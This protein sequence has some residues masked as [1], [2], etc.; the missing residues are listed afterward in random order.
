MIVPHFQR[1]LVW[2][3]SS[4]S[5]LLESLYY[6]T[7]CGSIIL[8]TPVNAS[9]QGTPLGKKPQYLIVDGQQRIRSLRN[10]FKED[11]DESINY[12]GEEDDSAVGIENGNSEEDHEGNG[13]WCL[14]LGRVR[15]LEED[16]NGGKRFRL[17]R[18]AN[19][20]R[21][22]VKD[23]RG[24]P[25]IDREALLPL[26]WFLEHTDEQ[27]ETSVEKKGD[28][29]LKK[30]AIAVLG[31][32]VVKKKLRSILTSPLFHVSTRDAADTLEDVVGIY[33][34]INTA[35]KR[36]ESEEKAFANLVSVYPQVND[37]LEEFFDASDDNQE[38]TAVERRD[39]LL[40]RQKEN[41]FGFKLFMRTFVQVLAYHSSRTIGAST[42]SFDSVN[43]DT[44][45]DERTRAHLHDILD[46]TANILVYLA[47]VLREEL[48]CDDFRMLPETSSFWPVI[49]LIIRFP[50][51]MADGK[52]IIASLALQLL[53]ADKQ[54]KE[55]LKLC[56][57]VNESQNV[58]GALELFE[59]DS[60][61]TKVKIEKTISR[62]IKNANSLM[63]RYTLFLYWLLR[64]HEAKD[65]SY[66]NN[67][68]PE[69][70]DKL[71]KQYGGTEA[72]LREV[73]KAEKQHI[74]PYKRLK[75]VF[76]LEGK[77]R[78]GR[79]EVHNIG[80]L[81]YISH[82]LNSFKT[83][84]GSDPLKLDPE[85]PDNL[86]AHLLM[87]R[88]DD[89]LKAYN[90][91]CRNAD[92]D[93]PKN[94]FKRARQNFDKFSKKRRAL[95][96][97]A[98]LL[99]EDDICSTGR[100]PSSID[101]SPALRLI[102]PQDPDLIRQ[103]RYPSDV[104]FILITL[105]NIKGMG[106]SRKQGAAVSYGFR[107]KLAKRRKVQ[108]VR[109]DLYPKEIEIKLSAVDLQ[110]WFRKNVPNIPLGK[111]RFKLDVNKPGA[112]EVVS[113]IL[114]RLQTIGQSDA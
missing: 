31:H 83:G 50:G 52:G 58:K 87:D 12:S 11:V 64:S 88:Q 110:E 57:G 63:N 108:V 48:L 3:E 103:L 69:K 51:L 66:D 38:L 54:K 112:A 42:F 45:N 98:F 43:A 92:P 61:L 68:S 29:A 41:R 99:W 97:E 49:Q 75:M 84:I 40:R 102:N 30:A 55:L 96:T 33:N 114:E 65:F 37:S 106:K 74:V 113:R 47:N 2:E 36:V 81:T 16:F 35:G 107:R 89:L 32:D 5:L 90:N 18:R 10:V 15:E 101:I 105:R 91:A 70:A 95:I 78:P 59:K 9:Q 71:K 20:P 23:V 94:D 39:N 13:I 17:F 22:A 44:M 109:V 111:D 76:N 1:G 60:D 67:T 27:I 26:R 46:T 73:V 86:E 80:N 6:G 19:D 25:L 4:V 82:G 21:M 104:E 28:A 8:W 14:N 62:G 53:L 85:P 56:A 93:N 34:R 24:A 79:H 77:A 7:P 72:T 100:L